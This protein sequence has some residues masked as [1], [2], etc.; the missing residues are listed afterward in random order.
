M[1]VK[2]YPPLIEGTLP[3]FYA[4]GTTKK[5]VVPFTMN[6]TVSWS[7]IGTNGCIIKM[8]NI[9]NNELIT[10]LEAI[11]ISQANSTATFDF[12][13]IEAKLQIGHSYKLQMAYISAD[14]D[15]TVGYYST[16]GIIKYTKQPQVTIQNLSQSKKNEDLKMYIGEY[17]QVSGDITEKIY[18]YNFT[19]YD[20]EN[21]ILET[22]G[23]LLHNHENNDSINVTNDTYTL[24]STLKEG[25]VYKLI[26]TT[27]SI[28][29]ITTSSP[30]YQI[31]Q[32]A[33]VLPD[34]QANLVATMNEENGY[35]KL[36]LEGKKDSL[37]NDILESGMFVVCRAS[38][39]DDYNVW[40]E[41]D[42]FVLKREKPSVYVKKDFTVQ[43]GYTYVYSLQQ[44]NNSGLYSG[45]LYSNSVIAAFEHSFL[46]DGKRQLKIKYN[47]KISSF[48]ETLLESKTNTLGGKYP[49]FFRNANVGYK[50][51]PISGLISYLMDEEELFLTDSEMFLNTKEIDELMRQTT[52]QTN[53]TSQNLN[54]YLDSSNFTNFYNLRELYEKRELESSQEN[55]I[56][57]KITRSTNLEDYN[58]LAERIFKTK[59]LEFLNDGQPKLFRSPGE[60][61]YMVRL[62]NSSLSPNDQVS[63]MIHTFNTQATEI[64][65]SDYQ[66]INYYLN[67]Y[68]TEEVDKGYV[69]EVK[70]KISDLELSQQ[71]G[72]TY[73]FSEA[74][75]IKYIEYESLHPSDKIIMRYSGD[76]EYTIVV[77]GDNSNNKIEFDV[78]VQELKIQFG[79]LSANGIIKYG[80]YTTLLNA[81]DNYKK[82]NQ[83]DQVFQLKATNFEKQ[84]KDIKQAF[85]LEN[86]KYKIGRYYI[87]KFSR[88]EL[89][90]GVDENNINCYSFWIDGVKKKLF[91]SDE[92]F[93]ITPEFIPTINLGAGICLDLFA[94]QL[95]IIYD[96]EEQ[97]AQKSNYD[98]QLTNYYNV[99][100]GK[101]QGN[102]VAAATNYRTAL[103][104]LIT[105][106]EQNLRTKGVLSE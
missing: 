31:I 67:I 36:T 52:L 5:I 98:T 32:Q 37:N 29:G 72:Y 1:G 3:A 58:I 77:V 21:N 69:N 11:E 80:H 42:R 41:I 68:I 16:V 88:C 57:N 34:I 93:I 8:K 30:E 60:G 47:P 46:Y 6:K 7:D 45:R 39:E 103:N 15:K 62:M 50:E 10:T 86:I 48:K 22:S 94:Q 59:V 9:Q 63:R 49:F 90:V 13:Q 44:Y 82:I 101:T 79:G 105:A 76:T 40:E 14:A 33:S 70:F 25:K 96:F 35:V 73:T 84:S 26:Y 97:L 100:K 20:D 43:H 75:N 106:I 89:D 95:E 104:S 87:L 65:N 2:L 19:L 18:S 81:F 55:K 28:S 83:K 91:S 54:E 66:T 24:K 51:F 56:A 85:E 78:P 64:D 12:S 38:S 102:A 23:E 99:L 92:T 27:S 61:S 71:N 53:V 17:S 74:N 4:S